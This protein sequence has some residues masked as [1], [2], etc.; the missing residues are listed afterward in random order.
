[1]A[2]Q[3]PIPQQISSYQFRLVGDMTL[4]QFL[5]LAGGALVGLMLYGSPLHPVIKW[6]LIV[7]SVLF[8]IALAFLP[9]EDRPLSTWVFIFFRS[10]YSPTLFIWQTPARPRAYFLPEGEVKKPEAAKEVAKEVAKPQILPSEPY[11]TSLEQKEE[12]F[13]TKVKQ[14]FIAPGSTVYIEP[15]EEPSLTTTVHMARPQVAVPQ[16]RRLAVEPQ[17]QTQGPATVVTQL[18]TAP[19]QTM[20]ATPFPSIPSKSVPKQALFS[21][22]VTPPLPPSKPNTI[23]GQVLDTEGKIVEGAILEI[24]DEAGRPVRALKTNKLG[25]FMIVTPLLN[26]RYTIAIEKEG[27]IFQDL[28]F[29]AKGTIIPPIAVWANEKTETGAFEF[30]RDKL[31]IP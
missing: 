19:F 1:M 14:T 6:P 30:T 3:H 11:I 13:L 20:A 27:L 23:V 29:E 5:Q 24:K 21:Q 10:I 2:E 25:H 17:A 8:G 26:G 4:K 18:N 12:T 22:D 16:E 31:Y 28:F 9:I 15:Q 7:I